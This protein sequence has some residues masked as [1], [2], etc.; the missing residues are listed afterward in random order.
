MLKNRPFRGGLFLCT[1][2]DQNLIADQRN[3]RVK[4]FQNGEKY[5]T[6]K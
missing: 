3:F 5:W 2:V 6:K 4:Y 1:S